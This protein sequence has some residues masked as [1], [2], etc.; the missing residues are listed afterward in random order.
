MIRTAPAGIALVVM[1]NNRRIEE[2]RGFERILRGQ[3][4]S[5]QHA[6]ISRAVVRLAGDFQDRTVV[7]VEYRGDAAMAGAKLHEHV[8]QR[9]ADLFVAQGA[10]AVDDVADPLLPAGI[11]ETGNDSAKIAAEGNRQTADFQGTDVS[12]SVI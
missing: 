6:A 9:A 11:E 3:V 10:H 1:R 5:D 12:F 4:G 7:L 8:V 2:R